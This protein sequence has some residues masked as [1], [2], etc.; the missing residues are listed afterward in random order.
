MFAQQVWRLCRDQLER[1]ALDGAELLDRGAN[2]GAWVY[3]PDVQSAFWTNEFRNL[4][5]F[6]PDAPCSL[7]T[8]IQRVHP[9]DVDGR[10]GA[11]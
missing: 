3:S 5:G 10:S 8:L 9:D 2:A 4:F 7:D 1:L 6:G 11:F